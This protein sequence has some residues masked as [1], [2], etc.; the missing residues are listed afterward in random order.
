[1]F[2]KIQL[3][4]KTQQKLQQQA[5]KQRSALNYTCKKQQAE[6][7]LYAAVLSWFCRRELSPPRFAS[8]YFPALAYLVIVFYF[9]NIA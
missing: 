7:I 9:L 1:M 4:Y 2:P 3:R 5:V 6:P 8:L